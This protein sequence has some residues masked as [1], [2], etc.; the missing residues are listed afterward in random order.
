MSVPRVK[1]N[2]YTF[3]SVSSVLLQHASYLALVYNFLFYKDEKMTNPLSTNPERY[4]DIAAYFRRGVGF[5]RLPVNAR[6]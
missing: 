2:I 1:T 3:P 4:V 6:A 5:T